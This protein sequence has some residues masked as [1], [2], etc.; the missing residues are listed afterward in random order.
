MNEE[1]G[2]PPTVA[3]VSAASDHASAQPQKSAIAMTLSWLRD[4]ML[5]VVIAIVVILFL[6]QPVKVEGTSMMPS[7]VDQERIFINKFVYKFGI[8]DIQ[9][10]DMIV[11]HFPADP[12]KSYIKRVIGLPG[13]T[14]AVED[15]VVYVN[16]KRLDETYVPDE[17][18][19][20]QSIP[21]LRVPPEHYYV[22]GDHRTS[23]N[24]SRAWGPVHRQYI[25]GKAVFVYWPLEK[26]GILH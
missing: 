6:Y 17:Y 15:G 8:G 11:F 12:S 26:M 19:D 24:D 22:L 25:Y 16:G 14:I 20:R 1:T 13:D 21:L 7:L 2:S 3:P 5:S 23:S 4:L 10:G 18:R 9:R